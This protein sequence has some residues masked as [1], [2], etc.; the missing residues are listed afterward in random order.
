MYANENSS[1]R[2]LRPYPLKVPRQSFA[3]I[4]RDWQPVLATPFASYGQLACFPVNVVQC[5]VD[6]FASAQTKS[7]QQEQNRVIA[8]S[9]RAILIAFFQQEFYIL[10]RQI[11]RYGCETPVGY[12]GNRR[13]KVC[14]DV[15]PLVEKP[16]KVP[17]GTRRTLG[18]PGTNVA[19]SADHEL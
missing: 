11:L 19:G 15:T 1:R 18:C 6:D 10:C 2:A 3:H 9:R 4:P 8:L 12:R 14:A 13:S 16:K 7:S 5:H 17:E